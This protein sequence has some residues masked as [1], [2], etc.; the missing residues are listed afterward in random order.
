MLQRKLEI[1]LM[2]CQGL[3]RL[4]TTEERIYFWSRDVLDVLG[5]QDG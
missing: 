4:M 1:R 5:T 2:F 3:Y